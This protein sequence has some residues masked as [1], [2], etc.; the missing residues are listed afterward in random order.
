[1]KD[2]SYTYS[3][4]DDSVINIVMFVTIV[5]CLQRIEIARNYFIGVVTL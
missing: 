3:H 5:I 2:N 4:S 1:M